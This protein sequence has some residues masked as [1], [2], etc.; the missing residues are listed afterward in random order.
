MKLSIKGNQALIK[1]I[2]A[3][4]K[5]SI[6]RTKEELKAW[7]DKTEMD[8]KRD[9]PV[10]TGALQSSIHST[11]EKEGLVQTVG[12]NVDY[13]PYVEFGTGTKVKVPQGLEKYAEGFMSPNT[14][15]NVNLPARPYLFGN[16]RNNFTEMIER[17]KRILGK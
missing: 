7:A 12:T 8:A 1:G 13:A 16:A 11:P 5:R 6:E 2:R 10:D 15:H 3:Y 14:D 9:V 17:L 4:E